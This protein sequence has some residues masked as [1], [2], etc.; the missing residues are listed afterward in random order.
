MDSS[1]LA[2]SHA[3]AERPLSMVAEL[4]QLLEGLKTMQSCRSRHINTHRCKIPSRQQPLPATFGR[5]TDMKNPAEA[6]FSVRHS[7]H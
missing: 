2:H 4:L 6:G 1:C 7:E 3:I 5:L